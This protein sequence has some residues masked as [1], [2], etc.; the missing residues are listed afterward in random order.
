MDF[1]E[2]NSSALYP[3][4]RKN[5]NCGIRVGSDLFGSV[6]V[7]GCGGSLVGG[8]VQFGSLLLRAH[9]TNT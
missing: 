8:R 1:G 2:V 6:S 5:N 4:N 9:Q 7:L 3:Y